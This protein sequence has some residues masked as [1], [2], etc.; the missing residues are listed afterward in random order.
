MALPH[1]SYSIS[2]LLCIQSAY[3]VTQINICLFEFCLFLE[4]DLRITHCRHLSLQELLSAAGW[5]G[6]MYLSQIQPA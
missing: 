6:K 4:S 2:S 1:G 5:V 3:Y